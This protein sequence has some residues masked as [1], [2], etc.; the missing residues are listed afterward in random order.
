MTELVGP[1]DAFG[2]QEVIYL[3]QNSRTTYDTAE[4]IRI[5]GAEECI[6]YGILKA[7]DNAITKYLAEHPEYKDQVE[8]NPSHTASY[9]QSRKK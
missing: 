3:R 2:M 8:G 7:N 6:K 5:I 4:V 1:T 9:L